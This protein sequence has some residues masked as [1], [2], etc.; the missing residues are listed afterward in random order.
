MRR[1]YDGLGD[2][3]T[4]DPASSRAGW[5][6]DNPQNKHGKH[7]YSFEDWGLNREDM[8]PY[9]SDYLKVHPVSRGGAA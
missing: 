5:L 2:E 8:T 1:V 6:A 9:F 7:V 4:D 3:W